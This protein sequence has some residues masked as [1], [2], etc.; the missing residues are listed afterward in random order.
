MGSE[1]EVESRHLIRLVG[2][3]AD[4]TLALDLL[5][6]LCFCMEVSDRFVWDMD[7]TEGERVGDAIFWLGTPEV[8]YPLTDTVLDKIRH[9]LS[10]G[11]DTLNEQDLARDA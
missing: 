6:D 5:G 7:T 8:N 9:Y 10:T 11:E 2:A 4:G 3:V 1:F